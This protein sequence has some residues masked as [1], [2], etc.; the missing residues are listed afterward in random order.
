MGYL[1][2]L[3]ISISNLSVIFGGESLFENISFLINRTDRIGLTGRNGAGKSTL[4]K[5]IKGLQKP[6]SGEISIPKEA[7]IGYLPQ[8]FSNHSVLSVK[9]ETRSCFEEAIALEKKIEQLNEALS[10][11]TDYESLDYLKIIE[12]L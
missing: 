11:R 1:C 2:G 5:I 7:T 10:S 4:L 12:N 3:M 6:T 9:E 8:E